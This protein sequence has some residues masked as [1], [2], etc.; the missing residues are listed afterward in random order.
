ML[1]A[2]LFPRA[3]TWRQP[4]RPST[5]GWMKDTQCIHSGL[6]FSH[7]IMGKTR[8]HFRKAGDT[9]A[10][11]HAKMVTIKDRKGKNVTVAEDTKKRWKEYIEELYK[12]GFNELDNYNGVVTHLEPD[13]L[14]CKVKW[15]LGSNTTNKASGGDEIPVELFQILKDDAVV[16][17]HLTRGFLCAVMDLSG[18]LWPLLIPEYSGIK[19]RGMFFP[20]LRNPGISSGSSYLIMVIITLFSL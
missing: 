19:R 1:I 11:L 13:T 14:E 3:E 6:L 5:D 16:R 10:T 9:N 17:K 8:D 12:K 7:K 2:A 20:G 18:N 15:A 4:K